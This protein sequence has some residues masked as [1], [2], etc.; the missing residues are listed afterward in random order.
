MLLEYVCE[1][2]KLLTIQNPRKLSLK[3]KLKKRINTEFPMLR[4][5]WT[6]F[7]IT[8]NKYFLPLQSKFF[9]KFKGCFALLLT[10][11]KDNW[12]S[13]SRK[14]NYNDC[15]MEFSHKYIWILWQNYTPVTRKKVE[16]MV[17]YFYNRHRW[18]FTR[19]PTQ[20]IKII[21]YSYVGPYFSPIK[22]STH[23]LWVP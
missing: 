10:K 20:I 17:M 12:Q 6:T 5:N 3:K 16:N 19:T 13:S 1:V 9:C 22:Y 18:S 11:F 2:P 14:K 21:L 15:H 8:V 7:S 23:T 4:E